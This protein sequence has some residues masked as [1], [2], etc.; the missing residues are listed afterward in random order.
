MTEVSKKLS[1]KNEHVAGTGDHQE[2]T[3]SDS[4]TK[5]LLDVNSLSGL[6]IPIHDSGAVTYPTATQEVYTYTLAAVTV[7]TL[8]INYTDSCK[9]DLLNWT[10][11]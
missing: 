8:T 3:G 2:I 4:G 1:A 11:L 9:D 6:S 10:T 5:R 7:M